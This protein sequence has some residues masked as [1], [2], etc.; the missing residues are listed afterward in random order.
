MATEKKFPFGMADILING[1]AVGLQGDAAV[2]TATPNYIDIENY[3][4]GGKWDK[5]LENWDVKLK[6]SFAEEDYEKYKIALP[7][8]VEEI[9][10]AT[11][12]ED[13]QMGKVV[14]LTDGGQGL[15]AR[16]SAFEITVHPRER[17]D[18]DLDITIFK[19]FPVGTFERKYGKEVS[20]FEVEFE[21]YPLT[22]DVTKEGNYYRIGKPGWSAGA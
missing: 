15:S 7:H 9:D 21:A 18:T 4:I 22:M 8:L 12:G 2:F 3:E 6:V 5:Y 16:D 13:G 11:M 17:K 20:R 14:G 10:D 19:A 1:K